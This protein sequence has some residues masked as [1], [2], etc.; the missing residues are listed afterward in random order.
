MPLCYLLYF[1]YMQ[2]IMVIEGSATCM[3][4]YLA[5][6]VHHSYKCREITK[7]LNKKIS[8]AYI[9]GSLLLFDIFILSFDIGTIMYRQVIL[10][11]DHCDFV[12]ENAKYKTGLF[13]V[14]LQ[15]QQVG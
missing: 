6:I 4:A 11:N 7:Q 5:Y 9:L 12:A 8:M 2:S 13:H 3:I 15:I 10:P 1:S 14:L